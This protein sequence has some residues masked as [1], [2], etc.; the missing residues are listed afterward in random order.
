LNSC[1]HNRAVEYYRK[2]SHLHSSIFFSIQFF[3]FQL[4]HSATT[5]FMLSVVRT[6][7]MLEMEDALA[8]PVLGF[9]VNLRT[10]DKI[11][12]VFSTSPQIVHRHLLKAPRG[13][14]IDCELVEKICNERE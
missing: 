12:A 14:K 1:S 6:Q 9:Q 10:P 4:N 2:K 11:C 3:F 8:N 5:A 7:A 13:H